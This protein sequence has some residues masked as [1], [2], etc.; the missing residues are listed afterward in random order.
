MNHL[1][2]GLLLAA[3]ASCARAA[4]VDVPEFGLSFDAPDGFKSVPADIVAVKW[5]DAPAFVIGD[6]RAA[7]TIAVDLKP[8]AV[9]PDQLPQMEKALEN[10]MPTLLPGLQWIRHELVTIDGRRWA[11]FEMTSQAQDTG[12]HNIML[13]TSMAGRMLVMNFNSTVRDFPSYEAAL[14]KGVASVRLAKP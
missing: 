8:T 1:L 2:I 4:T 11:F 13:V 12:I 6:E 3:V 10:R 14:R 7:T 9:R 5:K